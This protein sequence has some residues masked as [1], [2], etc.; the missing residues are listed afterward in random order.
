MA[1]NPKPISLAPLTPEE[2]LRRAMFFPVK[3][4]P[5][6]KKPAKKAK[7]KRKK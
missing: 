2:A 1:N 7:A 4:E 3:Q 5:A 6:P